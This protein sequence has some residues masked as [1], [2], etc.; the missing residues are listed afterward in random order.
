MVLAHAEPNALL[1]QLY[2]RWVLCKTQ[3]CLEAFK[4]ALDTLGIEP[5]AS[6]MPSGYGA[7]TP[8]AACSI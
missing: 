3:A 2:S 7:T 4:Y 1:L 8:C 6:R 5:R